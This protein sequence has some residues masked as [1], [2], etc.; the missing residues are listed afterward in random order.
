MAGKNYDSKTNTWN[1]LV[2]KETKHNA[3]EA[4]RLRRSGMPVAEIAKKFKLSKARIYQ[5]LK[6]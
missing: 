6:K 3:K 5:Y 2:H 1:D 4:A